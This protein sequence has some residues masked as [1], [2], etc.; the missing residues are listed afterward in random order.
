MKR[1]R[2]VG[3]LLGLLAIPATSAY[4]EGK[5][6]H[7]IGKNI[8]DENFIQ[9]HLG[10]QQE[11][12]KN[13]DRCVL[14]GPSSRAHFRDQD[15][16]LAETLD[17]GSDGIALSVTNGAFLASHALFELSANNPPLVTFDSDFPE[18]LRYL[19]LSYIGP[20][21]IAIG[22]QMATMLVGLVQTGGSFCLMTGHA[23]DTN[24]D[25]RMKGVRDHLATTGLWTEA[26]RCPWHTD[27]SLTQTLSQI[28][29]TLHH[30]L[31]SALVSI[32]AWPLLSQ[33]E[34]KRAV[35]PYRSENPDSPTILIA[36]GHLR[37]GD[38]ELV[39]GNYADGLLTIDF[40]VMGQELYRALSELAVGG[41]IAERITTPFH[42]VTRSSIEN[43]G[44]G[45]P[46]AGPLSN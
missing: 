26:T 4:A 43:A 30:Q 29:Y 45:M 15:R 19:R 46:C 36:T 17:A 32:G 1:R 18:Q 16:I 24:L 21:N 33:E 40:R 34:Y 5:L 12:R 22:R 28:R 37:P 41:T 35:Q 14:L 39:T 23:R 13:G 11:A 7:I 8:D 6:F 2:L 9:V 27:D 3:L 44:P 20:D 38:C 25:Q 42:A 31:A 10:C